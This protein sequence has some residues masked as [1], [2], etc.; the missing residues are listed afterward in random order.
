VT[1]AKKC[2]VMMTAIKYVE[3]KGLQSKEL[4]VF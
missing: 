3:E 2:P 4:K 1:D